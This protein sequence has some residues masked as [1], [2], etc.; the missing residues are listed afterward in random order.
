MLQRWHRNFCIYL[1]QIIVMIQKLLKWHKCSSLDDDQPFYFLLNDWKLP[2]TFL[3]SIES[4][5]I[6]FVMNVKHLR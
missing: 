4:A 5:R 2:D 1:A 3:V 6:A